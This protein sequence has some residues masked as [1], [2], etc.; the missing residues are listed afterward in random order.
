ML[1]E[2]LNL[3]TPRDLALRRLTPQRKGALRPQNRSR[4]RKSVPSYPETRLARQYYG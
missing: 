3:L 1:S 4:S 2:N